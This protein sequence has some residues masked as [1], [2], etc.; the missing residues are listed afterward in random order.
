M[1]QRPTSAKN[2]SYLHDWTEDRTFLRVSTKVFEIF[3]TGRW[4]FDSRI[5]PEAN[6]KA[7]FKKLRTSSRSISSVYDA[8]SW[9]WT[10]LSWK[11]KQTVWLSKLYTANKSNF[12]K[13]VLYAGLQYCKNCCETSSNMNFT[14]VQS[15]SVTTRTWSVAVNTLDTDAAF[16]LSTLYFA[17]QLGAYVLQIALSISKW[18]LNLPK[19]LI[20]SF[21]FNFFFYIFII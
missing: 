21:K 9:C 1:T 12:K 19:R 13:V 16:C 11:S 14:T 7:A 17:F 2:K 3:K 15:L 10:R 18:V 8:D 20:F 6:T 5:T 4:R